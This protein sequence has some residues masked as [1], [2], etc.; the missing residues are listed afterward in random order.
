MFFSG[1]DVVFKRYLTFLMKVGT[2]MYEN[3]EEK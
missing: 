3:S 1:E 2:F